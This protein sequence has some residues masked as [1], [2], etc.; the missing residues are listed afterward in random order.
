MQLCSCSPSSVSYPAVLFCVV[1]ERIL[2]A[3]GLLCHKRERIAACSP[4][5]C[6]YRTSEG[7]QVPFKVI[8]VVK[9]LGRTRLEANVSVR[10]L[11]GAKMFALNTVVLVP[12]PDYTAKCNIV[13]TS[14][15]AK[16]DATKKAIVS[17]GWVCRCNHALVLR[18]CISAE[19]TD[20]WRVS[21]AAQL[22][23]TM[24]GIAWSFCAMQPA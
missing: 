2:P 21:C 12:V 23:D 9:E 14:G 13:V 19:Q 4:A 22:C 1:G 17:A 6:S 24:H 7:I 8:P 10:S 15:K 20:A 18:P 16:Y 11:F 3:C 5:A